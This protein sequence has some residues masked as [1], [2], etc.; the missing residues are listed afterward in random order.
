MDPERDIPEIE[1][2][3][4]G[5][6]P[7]ARVDNTWQKRWRIAGGITIAL[8]GLM[9]WF[10]VDMN[11]LRESTIFFLVYWGVFALL[12]FVTL[13]I[14]ALDLRYIRAQHAIAQRDLFRETLGEKEFREALRDAVIEA[15]QETGKDDDAS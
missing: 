10:G 14:V 6:I 15:K 2:P 3:G 12:F 8:C 7:A 1:I 11:M 4:E 13:Y 5:R 9:A